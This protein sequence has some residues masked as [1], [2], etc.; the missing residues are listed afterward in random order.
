LVILE[1]VLILVSK[2]SYL[3][4]QDAKS[5]IKVLTKEEK[6]TYKKI[7]FRICK[8]LFIISDNLYLVINRILVYKIKFFSFQ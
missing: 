1:K 6:L 4:N 7:S 3:I 5:L 8:N 2:R